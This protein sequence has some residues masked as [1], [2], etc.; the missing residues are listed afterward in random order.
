MMKIECYMSLRCGSE[1]ALRNNLSMA[2]ELEGVEGDVIFRRT[3]DRTAAGLGL[4]GS[5]SVFIN[6]TEVQPLLTR[7]FS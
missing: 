3:D 5:P 1:V 6:G 4:K 2:L 7:G